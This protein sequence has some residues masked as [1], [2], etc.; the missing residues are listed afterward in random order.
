MWYLASP[1]SDQDESV[2]LNRF[3]WVTELASR[4]MRAGVFLFSP[5]THSHPIAQYGLPKGFEFWERFDRWLLERS[6]GVIVCQFPGWDRSI[7]VQN[8][9]RIARE[10]GIDVLFLPYDGM[11]DVD[12][13]VSKLADVENRKAING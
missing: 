1:Y 3:D 6:C 9:I 2:M 8:E 12:A 5:I 11:W 4:L 13:L 10:L 7:G